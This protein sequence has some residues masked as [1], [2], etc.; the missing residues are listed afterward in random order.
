MELDSDTELSDVTNRGSKEDFDINL[1]Y[2]FAYVRMLLIL[3]VF[4]TCSSI[5]KT[6]ITYITT[7]M[8]TLVNM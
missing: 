2:V 3:V 8:T 1:Y 7:C 4:I 5:I 6:F